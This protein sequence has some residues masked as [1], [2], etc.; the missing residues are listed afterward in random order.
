MAR[1]DH[2]P[3]FQN[4]SFKEFCFHVD[5]YEEYVAGKMISSGTAHFKVCF[6]Y[7]TGGFFS[8][9]ISISI[10]IE[11]NPFEQKIISNFSFD[12][13][14]TSGDRILFYI[15]AE[16]SNIYNTSTAMLSNL[17]GYTRR[18]KNFSSNEPIIASV[19]TI[20]KN[21][22]KVSFTFGNPERLIELY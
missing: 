6:K 18:L 20:D 13:A 2:W 7:N 17:I 1:F 14:I 22:A 3:P 21:I 9:K 19:F 12:G 4:F 11:N 5:R 8:N 15:I 10:K 16:E